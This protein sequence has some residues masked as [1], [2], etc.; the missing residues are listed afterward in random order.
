MKNEIHNRHTRKNANMEPAAGNES[1]AAKTGTGFTSPVDIT[2]HSVR[3]RTC[4]IDNISIKAVLDQL[5]RSGVLGG[6]DA[7]YIRSIKHTQEKGEPEMTIITASD[8]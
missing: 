4:D 2:V 7:Q 8:E 5:V 6:D 3:K 1:L